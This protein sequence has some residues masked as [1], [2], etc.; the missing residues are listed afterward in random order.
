M[1]AFFGLWIF[2]LAWCVAGQLALRALGKHWE[3][4]DRT[5]FAVMAGFWWFYTIIIAALI[6]VCSGK[7]WPAAGRARKKP[8]L[9]RRLERH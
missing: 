6:I 7:F 5:F 1:I 8:G 3:W 2:V 9:C 4:S